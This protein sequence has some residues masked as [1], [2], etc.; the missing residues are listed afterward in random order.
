ME[1]QLL[2][3]LK[4]AEKPEDIDEVSMATI[5]ARVTSALIE[6]SDITKE[7]LDKVKK[8]YS[9]KEMELKLGGFTLV[10]NATDSIVDAKINEPVQMCV[11]GSGNKVI[12]NIQQ[13][14]EELHG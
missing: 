2:E 14:M 1:Q 6:V 12:K 7:Y 11:L 13:I 4:K 8:I 3:T 10:L 5:V 9:E